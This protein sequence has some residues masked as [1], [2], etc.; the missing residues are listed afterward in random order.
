[1][2]GARRVPEAAARRGHFGR[3]VIGCYAVRLKLV[4]NGIQCE[5]SL[6]KIKTVDI[7]ERKKTEPQSSAIARVN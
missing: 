2:T 5:L 7:R 1:M 3:C 4:K 6:K